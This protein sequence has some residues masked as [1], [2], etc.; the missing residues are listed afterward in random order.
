VL[1]LLLLQTALLELKLS[2][3]PLWLVQMAQ[4]ALTQLYQALLAL[5]ALTLLYL[6]LPEQMALTAVTAQMVTVHTRLQLQ[7][8][9]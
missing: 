9:L 2:G 3:L 7:T 8:V 1:T 4:T 6:A 5:T